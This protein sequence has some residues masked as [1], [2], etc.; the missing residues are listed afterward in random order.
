MP[1]RL[2][3]ASATAASRT[4]TV[5]IS[6]AARFKAIAFAGGAALQTA[7]CRR[8]RESSRLAGAGGHVAAAVRG[9]PLPPFG[10][11]RRDRG[12]VFRVRER[13]R[14][15][16]VF[17]RALRR[18]TP[19]PCGWI[20][21]LSAPSRPCTLGV[22]VIRDNAMFDQQL[23]SSH[24]R[25]THTGGGAIIKVFFLAPNDVLDEACVVVIHPDFLFRLT[26]ATVQIPIAIT[27]A[28]LGR[29]GGSVMTSVCL[30]ASLF[31][32]RL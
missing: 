3:P 16:V 13:R 11:I 18:S 32:N 21:K 24:R 29:G 7:R 20:K 5:S 28:T 30:F 23:V 31:V 6:D 26:Y 27:S 4:F 1:A 25:R 15:G 14:S 19:T 22:G 17:G 12:A 10:R 2:S 9:A 8:R